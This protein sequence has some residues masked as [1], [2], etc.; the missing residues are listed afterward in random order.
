M[1]TLLENGANPD[2]HNSAGATPIDKALAGRDP[3]FSSQFFC[4]IATSSLSPTVSHPILSRMTAHP[5]FDVNTIVRT[6]VFF[7]FL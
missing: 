7:S 5:S 1:V 2:V 3:Q 6:N 4:K